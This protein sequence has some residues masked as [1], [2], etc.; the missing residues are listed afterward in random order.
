MGTGIH[1]QETP[2]AE[3]MV[4][5]IRFAFKGDR[6]LR[7]GLGTGSAL[8]TEMYAIISR[9]RKPTFDPKR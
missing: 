8:V 5:Q 2:D 7:A 4:D 3:I 6:V 1:T 9:Y